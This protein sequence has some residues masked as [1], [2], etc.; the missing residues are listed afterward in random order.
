MPAK[1][2]GQRTEGITREGLRNIQGVH[3]ERTDDDDSQKGGSK[4][5]KMVFLIGAAALMIGLYVRTMG[6]E[7]DLDQFLK[8]NDGTAVDD[9]Y[10]PSGAKDV[11]LDQVN[12]TCKSRGDAAGASPVQKTSAYV[13]CLAAESPKR[14]CQAIH[15]THF[16]A[17]MRNYY[18]T[19]AQSRETTIRTDPQVAEALKMVI[20]NGHIPRRDIIAAGPSDLEAALRGAEAKRNGC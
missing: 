17:A 13:A 18:R 8:K 2:F 10:A 12:K 11:F 20:V 7:Q 16:T 9:I 14:L 19:Q 4:L 6:S 3:F 15:R 1:Q 5:R